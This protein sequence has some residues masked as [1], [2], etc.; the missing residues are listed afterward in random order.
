MNLE[1]FRREMSRDDVPTTVDWEKIDKCIKLSIDRRTVPEYPRGHLNL[2]NV[3]SELSELNVALS[4]YICGE[5]SDN[6][7]EEFAD[8]VCALRYTAQI[9]GLKSEDIAKAIN[10]K[11]QR[12]TKRIAA[13]ESDKN[14]LLYPETYDGNTR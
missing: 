2:I 4:K 12:E 1:E 8:V 10:V 7:L 11:M 9:T 13:T 14:L 3:L 6:L 5:Q